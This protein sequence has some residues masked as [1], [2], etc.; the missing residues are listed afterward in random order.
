LRDI[1]MPRVPTL[2]ARTGAAFALAENPAGRPGAR[3]S[4]KRLRASGPIAPA[5]SAAARMP[6]PALNDRAGATA[7]PRPA[8]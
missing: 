7:Q 6:V 2:G 3:P 4:A 8:P 5:S 1:A